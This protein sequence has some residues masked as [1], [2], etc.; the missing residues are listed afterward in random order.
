MTVGRDVERAFA[1]IL[2][3]EVAAG[4]PRTLVV[5]G[6]PGIGKTWLLGHMTAGAAGAGF[7]VLACR[8]AAGGQDRSFGAVLGLPQGAVP[9]SVPVQ[10]VGSHL[11]VLAAAGPVL[12]VLDDAQWADPWT[13]GLLEHLLSFP[14]DGPVLIVV[15]L[16]PEAGPA[17]LMRA[18]ELAE[19]GGRVNSAELGPMSYGEAKALLAAIPD[20]GTRARIIASGG[21]NPQLLQRLA[22]HAEPVSGAGGGRAA[23]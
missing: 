4:Q 11:E 21:G 20:A 8:A 1:D 13:V 5:R 16:R 12:L 6:E 17:A 14:P 22:R 9:A 23:R 10:Q 15:A 2:V 7:R 19:R 18:V 3:A